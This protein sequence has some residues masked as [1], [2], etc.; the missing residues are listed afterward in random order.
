MLD[1]ATSPPHF[2]S[3]FFS[4]R[5]GIGPPQSKREKKRVT[6][7]QALLS[8]FSLFPSLPPGFDDPPRDEAGKNGIESPGNLPFLFFPLCLPLDLLR[9]VCLLMGR[10][11]Y[12]S[13]YG[14]ESGTR[15][16]FLFLFSFFF[17]FPF[18]SSFSRRDRSAAP[19][20]YLVEEVIDWKGR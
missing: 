15:L 2:P 12:M 9:D 5:G 1:R 13:C 16:S 17:F 6:A 7:R 18:I 3:L 11:N 14:L 4:G 8:F 20:F 10:E 19:L